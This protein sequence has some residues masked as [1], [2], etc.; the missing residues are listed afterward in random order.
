[1]AIE[2]LPRDF[3]D[4]RV[5]VVG[6]NDRHTHH[7]HELDDLSYE[8]AFDGPRYIVIG[9]AVSD[10]KLARNFPDLAARFGVTLAQLQAVRDHQAKAGEAQ[11]A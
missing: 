4:T 11:P 6:I 1:M 7:R 10:E 2:T 5:F 8:Q 9:P 3:S